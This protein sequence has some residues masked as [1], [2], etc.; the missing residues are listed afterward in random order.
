MLSIFSI[1]SLARAV[2]SGVA[3]LADDAFEFLI[4]SRNISDQTY[5]RLR[6][7][8]SGAVSLIYPQ[9]GAEYGVRSGR[10]SD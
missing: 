9:R 2:S 3:G 4:F 5:V 7:V 6:F 10:H 1:S 8:A